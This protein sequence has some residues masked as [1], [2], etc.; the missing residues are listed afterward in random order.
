M[1]VLVPELDDFLRPDEA[2]S[3]FAAVPNA[4]VVGV[5]GCKHLWVGEK[6][7]SQALNTIASVALDRQVTLPT[8]WDGDEAEVLPNGGK[9]HPK[10]T[11]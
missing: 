2:R 3:R 9:P 1:T 11:P 4:T 10:E 5:A 8:T 6:Y 7:V